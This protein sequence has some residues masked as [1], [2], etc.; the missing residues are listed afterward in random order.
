MR[1]LLG[2]LC[3]EYAVLEND[4]PD[5]IPASASEREVVGGVSGAN[6]PDGM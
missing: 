2:S 3:V 4:G 1:E 5:G 6:G